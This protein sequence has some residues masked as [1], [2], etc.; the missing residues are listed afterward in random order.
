MTLNRV[1]PRGSDSRFTVTASG[2]ES[3]EASPNRRFLEEDP[4]LSRL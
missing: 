3:G 1:V 4:P 2:M